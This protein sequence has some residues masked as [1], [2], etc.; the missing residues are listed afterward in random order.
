ML[1]HRVPRLV[2]CNTAD[3]ARFGERI[4]VVEPAAALAAHR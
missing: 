2:T 3:F 1:V 4:A